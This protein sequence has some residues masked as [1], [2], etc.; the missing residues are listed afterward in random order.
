MA[1]LI[2]GFRIG[3]GE[4]MAEVRLFGIGMAVDDRDMSCHE[5]CALASKSG[6]PIRR[7]ELG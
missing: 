5:A 6:L 1:G 2:G 7:I 4:R 3:G